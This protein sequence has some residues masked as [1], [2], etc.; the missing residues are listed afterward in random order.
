LPGLIGTGNS[1]T[2]FGDALAARQ[3]LAEHDPKL[4][5]GRAIL[6]GQGSAEAFL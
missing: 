3:E 5:H 6:F 4:A 1:L 2:A